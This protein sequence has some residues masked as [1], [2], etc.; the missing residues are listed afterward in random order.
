MDKLQTLQ[1]QQTPQSGHQRT[2]AHPATTQAEQEA[3]SGRGARPR[4]A[5]PGNFRAK[6]AAAPQPRNRPERG[7][8]S[9]AQ[10]PGTPD[11]PPEVAGGRAGLGNVPGQG[12]RWPTEPGPCRTSPLGRGT[13]GA[14]PGV[15]APA[16]GFRL[17][18][19]L[20]NFSG[21][22]SRPRWRHRDRRCLRGWLGIAGLGGN[23]EPGRLPPRP[24]SG[25]PA[26]SATPLS[27]TCSRSARVPGTLLDSGSAGMR[28]NAHSPWL[29]GAYSR[30]PSWA[31]LGGRR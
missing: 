26:S 16:L 6:P 4:P 11:P 31:T 13:P 5:A 14:T 30:R 23:C 29:R 25:A 24:S 10:S 17:P 9:G 28:S 22:K 27:C 12:G 18:P 7:T 20:L 21:R 2:R 19:G 1:R 8:S 3:V 15:H